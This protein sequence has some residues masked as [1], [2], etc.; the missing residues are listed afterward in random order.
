VDIVHTEEAGR[1]RPQNGGA[2]RAA[3][4]VEQVDVQRAEGV[5]QAER[6]G[7]AKPKGKDAAPRMTGEV[8]VAMNA[9]DVVKLVVSMA[10]AARWYA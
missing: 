8:A 7:A 10:P 1:R 6:A 5:L 3:E 2:A 9:M 4:L